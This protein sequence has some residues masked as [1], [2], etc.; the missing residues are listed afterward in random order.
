MEKFGKFM[1]IV[2][3]IVA[4]TFINGF[5]F[6]KLWFWFIVPIFHMQPL[7]VVEAIGIMFFI[8]FIRANPNKELGGSN[9]WEAFAKDLMFT[10]VVAATALV[11]G[12]VTSII[13]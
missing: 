5:V 7:R 4:S 1:T 9:F 2:L 8:T 11:S 10:F 6:S 13:I 12:W 3:G